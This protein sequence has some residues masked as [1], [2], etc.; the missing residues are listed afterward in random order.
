MN[1]FL[2]PSNRYT[3]SLCPSPPLPLATLTTPIPTPEAR[4][5]LAPSFDR[6]LLRL[7]PLLL[8]YSP[9]GYPPPSP[10]RVSSP[11]SSLANAEAPAPDSPLE[12]P[13]DAA[14]QDAPAGGGRQLGDAADAAPADVSPGPA[15]CGSPQAGGVV[16]VDDEAHK[17]DEAAGQLPA[18]TAEAALKVSAVACDRHGASGCCAPSPASLPCGMWSATTGLSASAAL[19]RNWGSPRHNQ[20]PVRDRPSH[21]LRRAGA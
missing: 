1:C 3:P 9:H 18:L 11:Y 16:E 8:Q 20:V 13:S 4:R 5:V 10:S 15:K 14:Q 2:Q 12:G 21:A 19:L 7:P 17:K 6:P